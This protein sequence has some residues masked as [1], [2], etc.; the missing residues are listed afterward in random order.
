MDLSV[1]GAVTRDGGCAGCLTIW[2]ARASLLG[3]DMFFKLME[4]EERV[5]YLIFMLLGFYHSLTRR[6]EKVAGLLE[7]LGL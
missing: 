3:G 4:I 5:P 1:Y 2:A 6:N 7:A